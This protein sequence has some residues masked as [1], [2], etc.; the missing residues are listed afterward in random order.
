MAPSALRSPRSA[1]AMDRRHSE[2]VLALHT[3]REALEPWGR[4][5][6]VFGTNKGQFSSIDLATAVLERTGPAEVSVWTWCIAEYEVQAVTAFL[7]DER[8]TGFRLVMDWAGAQRDMP[9]V[10]EMQER[11]GVDCIRVT[12]THAKIVTMSTPCGWRV[13]VRGS[14][15]LN[16]NRR[17]EQFDV[18]DDP[19]VYGVVRALEDELWQR[20]K[21][22]PIAAMKHGEATALLGIGEEQA[23]APSWAP[24]AKRWW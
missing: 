10:A 5:A 21:P 16:A 1:R 23:A 12:K 11:F 2:A 3:A 13:V 24:A 19:A 4:G 20:G 18:S 7:V 15:N 22:L 17:F 14:M 8:I 9:L 6:H